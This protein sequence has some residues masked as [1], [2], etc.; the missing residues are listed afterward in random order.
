MKNLSDLIESARLIPIAKSGIHIDPAKKG[1][2][3]AQATRMGMGVQEAATKILNAQ[4][5]RYSPKMR[6]KAAF[7]KA[8]KSFKH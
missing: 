2:F 7:A 1:T 6:K 5:G 8:A 4:E 3:T